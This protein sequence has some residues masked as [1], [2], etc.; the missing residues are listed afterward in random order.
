MTYTAS[1]VKQEIAKE[2]IL[3]FREFF[4]KSWRIPGIPLAK[5]FCR[6]YESFKEEVPLGAL[7]L[8]WYLILSSILSLRP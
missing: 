3:P 5:L 6:P 4:A 7:L 2:G 1:R 8:H